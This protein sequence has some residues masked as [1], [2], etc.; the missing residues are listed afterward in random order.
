MIW[1]V[2]RTRDDRLILELL[3]NENSFWKKMKKRLFLR[4]IVHQWAVDLH[5]KI[6]SSK[7][8]R[9]RMIKKKGCKKN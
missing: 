7:K 2:Q 9:C 8:K 1:S 5:E 3:N 6:V 4:K